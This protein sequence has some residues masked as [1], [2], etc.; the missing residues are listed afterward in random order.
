[1]SQPRKQH[2]LPQFYLRGFSYD[3]RALHQIEKQSGR[4]YGCQIKD[5][6]AI[7]DF[8]VMDYE[9]VE[10]PHILEKRLADMESKM[11]IYLKK[12]IEDG[13]QNTEARMYTLQFLSVMRLRV[14]AVKEFIQATRISGLRKLAELL[15]KDGKLP[16]PPPGLEETFKVKNLTF[17]INNWKV[18]EQIFTMA[19]DEK[20]LSIF[21]NMRLKLY[22]APPGMN[23]VTSDQPV[24]LFHPAAAINPYGFGP[25]MNGVQITFPLSANKLILLEHSSENH[26]DIVATNE[27]VDEFNRRTIAMATSYI[28]APYASQEL[29][30]LCE[31]TK[32]IHVGFIFDN[33]DYGERLEQVQRYQAVG[34]ST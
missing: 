1:M 8:H 26:E 29:L 22:T 30:D 5:A 6:A 21:Y 25:S 33:L 19:S 20:V 7:K 28:F 24:S 23:F 18:M 31:K 9:G 12:L 32:N 3:G 15:E 11:S 4:H 17:T 13:V 16:K 10:D 2:Y 34:P 14:P 27:E